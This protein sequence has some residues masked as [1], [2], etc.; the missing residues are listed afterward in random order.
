MLTLVVVAVTN[1]ISNPYKQI[2]D[3]SLLWE[4]NQCFHH[5]TH[6]I[7]EV[8]EKKQQN[9]TNKAERPGST[10]AEERKQT[11]AQKQRNNKTGKQKS[12]QAEKQGKTEMQ[13]QKIEKHKQKN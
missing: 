1:L 12:K 13:K 6:K 4:T 10:K 7:K 3:Q 5:G 11:K 9:K 2:D 8:E